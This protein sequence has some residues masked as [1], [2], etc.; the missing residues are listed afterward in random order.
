MILVCAFYAIAWLPQ[1][2][3]VLLLGLSI[4][5]NYMNNAYYVALF[6]GFLYICAIRRYLNV[7]SLM[8]AREGCSIMTF[9]RINFIQHSTTTISLYLRQ[10][11]HLR[12]KV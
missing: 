7:V 10:P 6:L 12:H 9:A 2:I 5:L 3:F 11:F 8:C 1:K 4:D